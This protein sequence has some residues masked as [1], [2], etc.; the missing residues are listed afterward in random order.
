MIHERETGR[1]ERYVGR[2]E[3][4]GATR[5]PRAQPREP[6]LVIARATAPL[7]RTL[8]CTR[9]LVPARTGSPHSEAPR[10]A[11]DVALIT[12]GTYPFHHGGVSVWCDQLARGLAPHRFHVHAITVTGTERPAWDLPANV[13]SVRGVPLWATMVARRP[14]RR[15]DPAL[16]ADLERLLW[17]ITQSSSTADF[18]AALK[19]LQ[20]YARAGQLHAALASQDVIGLTLSLMSAPVPPGR[21]LDDA[22]GTPTIA[23]AVAS[24]SLLE[25]VLRPLGAPPPVVDV[26]HASSNG[27][28]VLLAMGAKWESGTPFLLTEHGLYLRE[29]YIAYGPTSMGHA[30]R[31]FMLGFFKHLTAAAYHMAD[32]VAPGSEYNRLWEQANGAVPEKIKPI[33][34]GIDAPS[35]APP[36]TEPDQPTL[37]WVGR[38]DPLKDVKTLLRA[39]ARVQA[40]RPEARLRIFGATPKGNEPYHREC[41]ELHARLGLGDSAVFEGRVPSIIDAYH[42]GH[43]V[44]ATSISEGFPYAVIEGMAAG[45]ATVATDVGG[46]REAIADAGIL[47]SPRD[48]QAI[49]DA[50]L[51]LLADPERRARL[52]AAGRERVLSLFTLETCLDRYRELYASLT[53]AHHRPP[54]AATYPRGDGWGRSR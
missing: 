8:T 36:G 32:V 39:F 9:S 17:A 29:R 48:D 12:E 23:D 38:I 44:V 47:V 37:V 21:A 28:G 13:V 49:A 43:V 27:L 34:N 53:T 22:P 30:Q 5:R 31:A 25:H 19:R 42:A 14:A 7:G 4:A 41:V 26:C 15:L 46:V 24:L 2:S 51:E 35:F 18:L 10:R 1:R 11:L 40:A 20:P 54:A 50:C 33:Y 3:P 45:R 6:R 52:A 16:A